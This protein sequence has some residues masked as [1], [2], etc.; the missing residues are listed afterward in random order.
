MKHDDIKKHCKNAI[1]YANILMKRH[2]LQPIMPEHEEKQTIKA[3]IDFF[4]KELNCAIEIIEKDT[5][6][7]KSKRAE[8]EK[9]GIEIL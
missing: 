6:C 4:E 7:E 5:D 2:D 8:P 3:S 1:N 9:P